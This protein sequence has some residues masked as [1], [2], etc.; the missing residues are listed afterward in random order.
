[1]DETFKQDVLAAWRQIP[2]DVRSPAAIE[3]QLQDF[4][5]EFGPIPENFRWYLLECGGG[6]GGTEWMDSITQLAETHRRFR[7]E[8]AAGYWA[9]MT[10]VFVLGHDGCGNPYGIHRCT[11]KLLVEDHDFGG[12]H[13]LASSFADYLRQGLR[14]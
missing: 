9:G 14:L 11:G 12:V 3:S 4:E 6:P 13:E 7:T 5:V 1:M 10:E 2:E 8:L